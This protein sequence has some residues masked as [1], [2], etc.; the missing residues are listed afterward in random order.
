MP[1]KGKNRILSELCQLPAGECITAL[2]GCCECRCKDEVVGKILGNLYS[3]Q[4]FL[5]SLETISFEKDDQQ[6]LCGLGA[7]V[8]YY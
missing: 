1:L 5:K 3:R 2:N 7:A 4:E 6:I 8:G